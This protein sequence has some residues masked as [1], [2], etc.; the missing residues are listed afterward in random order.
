[1]PKVG[2]LWTGRIPFEDTELAVSDSGGSGT[3]V[4]YLNG[5]FA[6]QAY[7][8]R[9]ISGLGVDDWRHITFDERARGRS[10]S[11]CDYSFDAAL[12]DVDAVLSGRGIVATDKV[13]V[14]GWSYGAYVAAH[15]ASQNPDRCLGA[16]FVDGAFPYDWLDEDMERRIRKLFRQLNWFMPLLRPTG[17]VPRMTGEQQANSNI[18]LG[19]VSSNAN[20]LPVLD[21][22]SV[23]A[24][25]VVA[26]GVSFGSRGNEQELCRNSTK[27]VCARNSNI[28]VSTKVASDHGA[29]LKKDFAAVVNA[30]RQIA[31]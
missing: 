16:V 2:S 22:I 6:T 28:H 18:E 20:F 13:L 5:Q 15:W 25:Y 14:V 26:S 27:V 11:S 17:L 10:K 4:I 1:M 12:R 7:W 8:K 19:V 30:V 3:P 31:S 9:V 29:V 21:R 23:P 24:L